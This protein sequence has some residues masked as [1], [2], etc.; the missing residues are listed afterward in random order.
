MFFSGRV[1]F[2]VAHYLLLQD[3]LGGTSTRFNATY[4]TC[5]CTSCKIE[6]RKLTDKLYKD[7]QVQVPGNILLTVNGLPESFLKQ[8]SCEDFE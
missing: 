2:D 7:Y 5:T 4:N 3:R 1:E 8:V 6:S